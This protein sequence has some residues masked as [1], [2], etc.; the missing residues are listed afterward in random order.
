MSLGDLLSLK[1]GQLLSSDVQFT[2]HPTDQL[3]GDD[4]PTSDVVSDTIDE[5]LDG[6][7]WKQKGIRLYR[8]I[9]NQLVDA[10]EPYDMI[11]LLHFCCTPQCKFQSSGGT[12]ERKILSILKSYKASGLKIPHALLTRS[13]VKKLF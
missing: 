7:K 8:C 2:I 11:D 13:S 10:V 5:V 9:T 6:L 3:C 12:N 1:K 4:N